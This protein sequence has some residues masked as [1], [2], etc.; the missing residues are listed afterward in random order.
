[1]PMHE[2]QIVIDYCET[3]KIKPITVH[4]KRPGFPKDYDVSFSGNHLSVLLLRVK[5]WILVSE[6][7]GLTKT[8]TR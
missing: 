4:L 5:Q 3:P 7:D 8:E 1:M 2:W 6:E